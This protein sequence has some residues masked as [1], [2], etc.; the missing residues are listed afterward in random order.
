MKL[1]YHT[2]KVDI[3][4]VEYRDSGKVACEL[5]TELLRDVSFE[6][7]PCVI[8]GVRFSCR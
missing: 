5:I 7:F 6:E 1:H 2:E 8:L 4:G 3:K